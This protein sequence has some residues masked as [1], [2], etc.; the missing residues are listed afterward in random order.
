MPESVQFFIEA[1][2][3]G[4]IAYKVLSND[5]A[6]SIMSNISRGI[7]IKSSS[8]WLVFISFDDFCS[9]LTITL[10]SGIS[11][12]N[13]IPVGTP[14]YFDTGQLLI[15]Q[16]GITI[17]TNQCKVWEPE[18]RQNLPESLADPQ[19]RLINFAKE[20]LLRK[21]GVGL[22]SLLPGFLDLS[23]KAQ[24]I[25]PAQALIYENI[26]LLQQYIRE[27]KHASI[28]RFLC[29]FLG[30][31]EGLTPSGDDFVVGLLLI[32]NRW[33]DVFWPRVDINGLNREIVET[34]YQKTT[35]LSANLIE[36]AA[37]G[38]GDGRLIE[39][40]DFMM[41]GCHREDE[42]VTNILNWGNS[43]GV[44]AFVGMAVT[45]SAENISLDT[46]FL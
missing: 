31:G 1:R 35:M 33:R 43:S 5:Q 20:V 6:A 22:S 42:V 12:P 17:D 38:Q 39:A 46:G 4:S 36:C 40:V 8:R 21:P 44:D 37:L 14:V 9:P 34:A 10:K 23:F 16:V 15:P 26:L 32:L 28:G 24:S 41:C 29:N 11:L 3:I 13:P 27:E 19:K 25:P 45:L 2:S 30:L 7:F 18:S